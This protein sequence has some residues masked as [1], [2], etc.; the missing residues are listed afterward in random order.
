MK[1]FGELLKEL[2][3]SRNI[4]FDAFRS[5]LNISKAYLN[6]IE[7]GHIKPPPNGV[8]K[9]II[10]VLNK[11]KP[12]TDEELGSLYDLA[13]KQRGELPADIVKLLNNNPN[14]IKELRK[15]IK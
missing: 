12:L 14:I 9:E 4:G 8:Q 3:L 1:S 10:E 5:Q 13:A 11:A 2:R 7:T 15:Q 6:D